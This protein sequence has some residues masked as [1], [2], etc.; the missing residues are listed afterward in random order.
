[1]GNPPTDHGA[2]RRVLETIG[3]GGKP[4]I[5]IAEQVFWLEQTRPYLIHRVLRY[6]V[7]WSYERRCDPYPQTI[8]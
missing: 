2:V 8:S 4:E 1:M 6:E 5:M 3:V 7:K